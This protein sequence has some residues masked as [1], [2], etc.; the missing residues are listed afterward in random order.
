MSIMTE[1]IINMPGYRVNEYKIIVAPHE[2]LARKIM[3]L[4][5]DFIEE[6]KMAYKNVFIPQLTL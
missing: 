4:Q 3:A 1:P 2:E 5:K 6:Y